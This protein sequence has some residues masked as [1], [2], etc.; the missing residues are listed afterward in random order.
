M[1]IKV[2]RVSKRMLEFIL[3]TEYQKVHVQKSKIKIGGQQ[4][5]LYGDNREPG[6]G[7]VFGLWTEGFFLSGD[8]YLID[9]IGAVIDVKN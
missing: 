9:I 2:V 7:K 5:T 1:Q 4:L 6:V 8:V 3:S